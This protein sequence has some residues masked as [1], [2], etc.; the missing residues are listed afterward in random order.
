MQFVQNFVLLAIKVLRGFKI[1][2]TRKLA[3]YSRQ[4]FMLQI[5]LF[6]SYLANLQTK[7]NLKRIT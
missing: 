6:F 3:V 4:A 7:T 5:E 2:E 1:Y